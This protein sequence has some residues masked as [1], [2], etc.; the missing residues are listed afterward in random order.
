M[1]RAPRPQLAHAASAARSRAIVADEAAAKEPDEIVQPKIGP[2]PLKYVVLCLLVLQNSLTAILAR[3]SRV[4]RVPGQQLYLGSVAVFMAE[5]IKLPVCTG[6]IVRDAGGIETRHEADI[7]A[8]VCQMGRHTTHGRA[9]GVLLRAEPALLRRALTALRD[10]LPA[11]VAV[12]DPLYRPLLCR[13]PRQSP[14]QAAVDRLG[15]ALDGRR[16]RPILRGGRRRGG[17]RRRSLQQR[18]FINARDWRRRRLSLL[19]IKRFCECLLREGGEDA[20]GGIHLDAECAVGPLL[21]AAGAWTLAA[22]LHLCSFF[23]DRALFLA[24]CHRPPR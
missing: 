23:A 21:A 2:F 22:H 5:A 8:G 14:T 16:A 4:P 12:E 18:R 20:A 19:L 13:L 9:G 10:V 15:T 3:E 7:S 11:M 17:G 1:P 6:L 24:R